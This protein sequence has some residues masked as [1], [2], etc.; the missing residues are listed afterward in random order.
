MLY[1]TARHAT[2][3]TNIAVVALFTLITP[4]MI[5]SR[6][7]TDK[8]I[9]VPTSTE[10]GLSSIAGIAMPTQIEIMREPRTPTVPVSV[11]DSSPQN[12][13]KCR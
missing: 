3:T 10:I 7:R 12:V 6:I 5:D 8:A 1:A 9:Q 4:V 11:A 13:K 2:S